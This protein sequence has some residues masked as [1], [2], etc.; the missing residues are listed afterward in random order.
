MCVDI[1]SILMQGSIAKCDTEDEVSMETLDFIYPSPY[2]RLFGCWQ[3]QR[4]HARMLI[5]ICN[6]P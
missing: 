3:T 5:N 2:S 1:L 6:F 4:R